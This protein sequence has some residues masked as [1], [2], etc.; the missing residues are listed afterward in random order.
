MIKTIIDVA[1]M[2]VKVASSAGV[3]DIVTAYAAPIIEQVGT[4]KV[5]KVCAKIAILGIT[6]AVS[7]AVDNHIDKRVEDCG[8]VVEMV[9]NKVKKSEE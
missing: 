5:K 8:D 1:V 2:G 9:K 6:G 7:D 4:S 3:T